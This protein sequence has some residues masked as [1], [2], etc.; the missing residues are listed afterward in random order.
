MEDKLKRDY[1]K[2]MNR[3]LNRKPKKVTK[4]INVKSHS[5]LWVRNFTG[6]KGGN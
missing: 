6:L 2:F 4:K 1:I 5:K 3:S